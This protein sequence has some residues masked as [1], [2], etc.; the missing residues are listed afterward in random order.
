MK[1]KGKGVAATI[2]STGALYRANPSSCTIKINPDATVVLNVSVVDLGQ[3]SW[4]VM[5]QIAAEEF[6]IDMNEIVLPEV[7]TETIPFDSGQ[8]GSRTTFYM[9]NAVLAAVKK[10]KQEL[11]TTAAAA[12]EVSPEDLVAKDGQIYSSVDPGKKISFKETVNITY[13]ERRIIPIASAS[14]HANFVQMD[15]YTGQGSP[16]AAF[17]YGAT[18]AEV[19]VDTETGEVEVLS[20]ISAYDCGKALNPM[21]VEGQI[22][23]GAIMSLGTTL[24][25]DLDPIKGTGFQASNFTE[26]VIPTALDIPK[27][28]EVKLVEAS[29]PNGP[30]GAK[31]VGELTTNSPTPAIVNAIY[32]A[33]GVQIRDL[34]ITPEKVLEALGKGCDYDE[35]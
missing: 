28:M 10:V 25:E 26:Y 33:I 7:N 11:F 16:A 23:G 5:T 3:G 12:L 20:L 18:L 8:V 6:G 34:P 9:G 1:K 2:F 35:K 24:Y 13:N 17:S 19:E 29:D 4:T 30:F 15:P 21:A 32:D 27:N 31:G 14:Y 22:E